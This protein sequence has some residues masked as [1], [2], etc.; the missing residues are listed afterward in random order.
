[1]AR[2]LAYSHLKSHNTVKYLIGI[3][4]QGVITFVSQA[5]GKRTTDKFIMEN[6]GLLDKLLPGDQ[7]MADRGFTC[8]DSVGL[9]CA[10]LLMPPF[11]RGKRQL[12]KVEVDKARQL[13][14]VRIHVER[15][16]GLLRKKYTITRNTLPINFLMHNAGQAGEQVAVIDKVVVVCSALCNCCISVVLM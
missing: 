13:S 10:E 9:H 2:A 3:A 4:P 16:I 7:V 5:W 8:A 11:T 15:V 1:M 6:C 12:S 14:R